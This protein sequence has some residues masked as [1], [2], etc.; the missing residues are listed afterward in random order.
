MNTILIIE[1]D[2]DMRAFY[3]DALEMEGYSVGTVGSARNAIEIL[4][5]G[6]LPDL[7]LLDLSMPGMSGA[8]FLQLLRMTPE[9]SQIK[10]I[11]ISGW[12]DLK[13]RAK[14]IGANGYIKKPFDLSLL[15]N[16]VQKSLSS[17]T[18]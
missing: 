4:K 2:S 15:Y 14:E 1:D 7:I 16:E 12:D 8:E 18:A 10:V 6:S 9:W 11:I 5:N 13:T 17:P 3:R